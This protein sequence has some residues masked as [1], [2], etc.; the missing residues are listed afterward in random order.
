MAYRYCTTNEANQAYT[1]CVL[2]FGTMPPPLQRYDQER[3]LFSF[4]T[5]AL[6]ALETLCRAIDVLGRLS[7]AAFTRRSRPYPKDV[8]RAFQIAYP[9]NT[10]TAELGALTGS[11]RFSDLSDI[12][13]ALSHAG[14]PPRRAYAGSVD[15]NPDWGAFTI[16]RNTTR[17]FQDWMDARLT[18]LMKAAEA[19]ATSYL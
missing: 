9:S 5:C 19:F 1:K 17:E 7:G 13:N 6:S 8:A 4:F 2:T 12:R 3:R 15:Q 10:L 16:D 18:D 14:T 11:Q